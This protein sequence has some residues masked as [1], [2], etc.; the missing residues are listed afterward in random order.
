MKFK[1]FSTFTRTELLFLAIMNIFLP[2]FSQKDSLKKVEPLKATA[3]ININN[4][5]ISLFP[6]LSFGK[7]AVILILS[8]GKKNIYFEPEL[9]WGLNGKPWSYIYWLRY[10]YR[11]T[12]NFGVNAGVHPSYVFREVAFNINGIHKCITCH[13][14]CSSNIVCFTYNNWYTNICAILSSSKK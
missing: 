11:K 6:N 8:V 2:A 1:Q 10:K 9:R 3:N 4:N 13:I 7:P 5:G 14:Y 12:E